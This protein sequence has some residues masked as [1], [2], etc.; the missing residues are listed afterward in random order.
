MSMSAFDQAIRDTV[1]ALSTGTLRDREGEVLSRT[2]G[3]S[4]L[5][6]RSWREKIGSVI[7]LLNTIVR[8]F[9]IAVSSGAIEIH[10]RGRELETYCINDHDLG[11]WMDATRFEALKLFSEVLAEAGIDPPPYGSFRHFPTW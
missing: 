4:A 10:G 2:I 7:D 3:R 11:H 5:E 6:N 9:E 1:I 8:R